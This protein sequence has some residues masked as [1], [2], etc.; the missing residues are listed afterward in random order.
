MENSTRNKEILLLNKE[1]KTRVD[2]FTKFENI[3]F[4]EINVLMLS[5]SS[6]IDFGR[7]SFQQK[8]VN[9]K[10]VGFKQRIKTTCF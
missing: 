4:F 6:C 9:M 10:N 2:K 7:Q 3:K 1:Y 5:K 8:A